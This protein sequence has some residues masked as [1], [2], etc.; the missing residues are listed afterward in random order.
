MRDEMD[1]AARLSSAANAEIDLVRLW[2][3]LPAG[4]AAFEA[5]AAAIAT[6]L[7]AQGGAAP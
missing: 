4:I 6:L 5:F 7:Q 1:L 3:E 2:N